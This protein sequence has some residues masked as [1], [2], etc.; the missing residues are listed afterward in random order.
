MDF[1]YNSLKSKINKEKHGIDFEEAKEL[2]F[3]NNVVLPALTKGEPRYMIIG[4]IRKTA[5]SGIFTIR[6][7]AIRIISCRK[8]RK[9]EKKVYD[10][11]IKEIN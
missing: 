11:K 6:K 4:N 8:A 2:W 10:E 5:Y 9:K 3:N 7:G 1:E